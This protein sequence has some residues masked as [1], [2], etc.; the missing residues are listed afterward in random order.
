MAEEEVEVSRDA[1]AA[2]CLPKEFGSLQTVADIPDMRTVILIAALYTLSNEFRD[3][4]LKEFADNLLLL[5]RS[6]KR[7]GVKELINLFKAARTRTIVQNLVTRAKRILV[8]EHGGVEA[9]E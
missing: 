4:A 3:E 7:K 8:G 5:S 6:K 2:L 9:T 1:L